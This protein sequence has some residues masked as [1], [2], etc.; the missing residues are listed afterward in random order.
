ML[1]PW[2]ILIAVVAVLGV[3]ACGDDDESSGG[4]AD[5]AQQGQATETVPSEDALRDT[6]TKPVIPKPTGTPPRRLV[7]QDIVKGK[8]PGAKPGDT[9]TVN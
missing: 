9:V 3:A 1:R 2:L 7:K 4:G 6:S 8:G 5:D